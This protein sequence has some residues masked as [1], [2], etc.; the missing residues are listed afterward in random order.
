M[1]R[2]GDLVQYTA[3][4]GDAGRPRAL[5]YFFHQELIKAAPGSTY[6]DVFDRAAPRVT[7][8]YQSQHPQLEGAAD[9]ELFGTASWLPIGSSRS[10]KGGGWTGPTGWRGGTRPDRRFGLGNLSPGDQESRAREMLGRVKIEQV[11]GLS[12]TVAPDDGFDLS[13]VPDGAA[14]SRSRTTT[15]TF[16]WQSALVDLVGGGGS[17]A[18]VVQHRIDES[19]LLRLVENPADDYVYLLPEGDPDSRKGGSDARDGEGVILGSGRPRRA[20]AE[21][22]GTI[23][24]EESLKRM[25]DNLE[26]IARYRNA[27]AIV[28]PDPTDRLKGKVDLVLLRLLRQDAQGHRIPAGPDSDGLV[29]YRQ[30]DQWVPAEPGPD[31]EVAFRD[32]DLMAFRL[33]NNSD[34]PIYATVLDFGLTYRVGLLYPMP[35]SKPQLA[36]GWHDYGAGQTRPASR[37][38]V[39]AVDPRRVPR[40]PGPGPG[41][42]QADRDRPGI[43]L[44]LAHPARGQG[45]RPSGPG[46]RLASG[47]EE[48]FASATADGSSSLHRQA[49]HQPEES[50]AERVLDYR[51]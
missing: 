26:A 35:N 31:G 12:S 42:L 20:D 45:N 49:R 17:A 48:H 36:P 18:K 51:S 19:K 2:R 39:G 24:G 11:G 30:G 46:E 27:L 44:L 50:P 32:G 38:G 47:P 43:G 9:R 29:R 16:S 40:R 28:N 3:Y 1:P 34:I 15:A 13:T 14:P 25:V 21:R 5:T 10:T 41:G 4:G 23:A 7:A 6:R 8:A 37:R 33:V 22:P